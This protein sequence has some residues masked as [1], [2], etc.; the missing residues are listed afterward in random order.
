MLRNER[1]ATHVI[2]DKREIPF[3]PEEY[4]QFKFGDNRVAAKFGNELFDYFITSHAENLIQ[5]KK[6]IIVF[7]SPYKIMP[8]A[9]FYLA[10]VFYLKLKRTLLNTQFKGVYVDFQKIERC[11]TYTADYGSLSA[12]DRLDLIQNDT[13]QIVT[14][15]K[16]DDLCI[17][18]DDISITGSHQMVI[19]QLIERN[20]I[21]STNFFL[22]YALLAEPKIHPSFENFLNYSYLDDFSKMVKLLISDDFRITT[23]AS[24]YILSQSIENIHL[25]LTVLTKEGKLK[26]CEE[27][28]TLAYSNEYH[29]FE[30]Y[31][32]NLLILAQGSIDLYN[33]LKKKS[34]N[35]KY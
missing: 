1:H 12:K 35:K 30:L 20:G 31:K 34:I 6:R 15:P 29:K 5:G 4:S 3:S 14:I 11:Q 25:L 28:V 19:E 10:H 22:Y 2:F 17:F 13:Y 23:R 21:L 16:E 33:T 18:I 26:T 8:T 24:K 9:S 27:L 7:S 32:N